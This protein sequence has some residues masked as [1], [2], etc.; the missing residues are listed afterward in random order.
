M[1]PR[2]SVI[3]PVFNRADKVGRA[4]KSVR[5]AATTAAVTA[6]VI[7]VDD[8]S[9]D[10]SVAIAREA[11]ADVLVERTTNGGVTAA[12]NDAIDRATGEYLVLL[13]SDDELTPE[14]FRES[15]R[16]FAGRPEIDI[17]FGACVDRAGKMMHRRDAIQGDAT[18]EQLLRHGAGGE[19]MPVSKRRIFEHLRFEANLRGFESI[20]WLK[21]VR[22]GWRIH[23]SNVVLRIYDRSGTDRLCDRANM[24]RA[25]ARMSIGWQ[26]FLN[27]F[28]DDLWCLSKMGYIATLLRLLVYGRMG[29]VPR[30]A[31]ALR[32]AGRPGRRLATSYLTA[33]AVAL[34]K[35]MLVWWFE[36]R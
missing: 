6:E 27:E 34:P 4:I 11:G 22:D 14:A 17:L 13:D 35:S 23:Y 20:T 33:F 32:V 3:V 10:S 29:G 15:E 21:I 26:S 28:G 12:R 8:A 30:A 16:F 25:S 24:L 36:R 19:F 31:L 2:Y 5:R 18:Y 9:T 1:S 7:V